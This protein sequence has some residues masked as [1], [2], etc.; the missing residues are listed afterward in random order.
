MCRKALRNCI[1]MQ[2]ITMANKNPLFLYG[3]YTIPTLAFIT[4]ISRSILS[5]LSPIALFSF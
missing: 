5:N 2:E 4:P 1:A 3:T